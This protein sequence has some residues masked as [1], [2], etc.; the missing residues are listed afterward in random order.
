MKF[1][2]YDPFTNNFLQTYPYLNS[3]EIESQVT[4]AF[5]AYND[6]KLNPFR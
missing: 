5:R 1:N 2:T 6:N 4:C 3:D